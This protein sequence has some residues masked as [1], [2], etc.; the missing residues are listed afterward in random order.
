MIRIL[1][2]FSNI[3]DPD[4]LDMG[5]TL[6]VHLCAASTRRLSPRVATWQKKVSV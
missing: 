3:S 5:T 1:D 6:S 4:H 2:V